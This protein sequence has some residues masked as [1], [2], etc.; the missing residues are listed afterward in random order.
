M[1]LLRS[2]QSACQELMDD[3]LEL[4]RSLLLRNSDTS[5]VVGGASNHG[6]DDDSDEEI[7]SDSDEE[8]T[9]QPPVAMAT[10]KHPEWVSNCTLYSGKFS[11]CLLFL[12]SGLESVFSWSYFRCST[13][14]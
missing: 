12:L 4:Q 9:E 1:I 11:L 8:T 7:P 10:S 6:N 14:S 3:L 5:Y 13:S 2:G